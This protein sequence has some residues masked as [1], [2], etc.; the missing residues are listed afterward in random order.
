MLGTSGFLIARHLEETD[1]MRIIQIG[2]LVVLLSG[3]LSGAANACPAGYQPCG[4]GVCCP[5]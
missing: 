4:R 3:L 1:A 5:R 2:L